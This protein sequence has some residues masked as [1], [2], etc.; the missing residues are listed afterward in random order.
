MKYNEI[1]DAGKLRWQFTHS[2]CMHCADPACLKACSTA[3]AII[4]RAN[5][6]V[7]FDSDKCIGC[8]Y[9]ASACPFD[10]PKIS[11]K[12]NKAYKCTLCSDRTAV[13][14][15]P[16]CV[17]TCT[18][19]ALRYGTREDM[20]FYAEKRVE[21]LKA[22]GY[23]NAGLYNPE[24][25]GGTAMMMIFHDINDPESYYMPK[26]PQ[27]PMA[28]EIRQ[29]WLKPL[30]TAGLIATAAFALMHRITVGRNIVEEDQ[31]GY[32]DAAAEKEEDSK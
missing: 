9:C 14:L 17:K 32:I 28:T 12:D 20:L 21:E 11:A 31:P 4:Q 6:T 27:V 18:T 30:G 5:G 29:D 23:K 8:G 26:D 25:V 19:G 16:S 24:G 22:R 10:I 13:G 7:D 3:G 2:A 1:E 15:E